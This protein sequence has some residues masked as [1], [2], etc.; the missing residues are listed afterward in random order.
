MNNDELPMRAEMA[1]AYVDGELDAADRD[2]AAADPEAMAMA[3][4]VRTERFCMRF[5]GT[6]M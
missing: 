5:P 3:D 2:A 6:M 1:S 4:L